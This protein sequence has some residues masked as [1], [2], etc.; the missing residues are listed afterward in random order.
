MLSAE[1]TILYVED[2]P[3][4]RQVMQMIADHML[5][6]RDFVMLEDSTDFL[7]RIRSLGRRPDIIFLDIQVKPYDGFEMVKMIRQDPDLHAVKVVA[8]TASAI[9]TIRELRTS[10]FDG[11]I[12]KPIDTMTFPALLERIVEGE[13]IWGNDYKE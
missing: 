13:A 4:C 12:A 3:L 6:I 9:D 1:T 2:D 10:G 7:S 5:H 11:V 8:I